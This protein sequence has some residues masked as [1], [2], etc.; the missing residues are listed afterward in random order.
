MSQN[1]V[2]IEDSTIRALLQDPR[3]VDMLPCLSGPK[4]TLSSIQKGGSNC[5]RCKAEKAQLRSDAMR[6][7]R[8]CIKN[9]RG[10][11]LTEIKKALGARQ[12]RVVARN[13]KGQK[14]KYTL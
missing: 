9:A 11:R 5:Q 8:N 7:A 10:Q 13:A 6:T 2:T 12:I 3:A 4:K 1:L 14:V